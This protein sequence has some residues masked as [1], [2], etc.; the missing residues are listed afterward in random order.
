MNNS[1]KELENNL[2]KLTININNSTKNIDRLT[3]NIN[4]V[5]EKVDSVTEGIKLL[6][7]TLTRNIKIQTREI[8]KQTESTNV[9]KNA[10]SGYIKNEADLIENEINGYIEEFLQNDSRFR[11][12]NIFKVDKWEYLNI[13]FLNKEKP[14][15][16]IN[17]KD[18]PITEFD[19]LF[20]MTTDDNYYVDNIIRRKEETSNYKILQFIVVEGKHSISKE[21]IDTK[22]K[23][24][25]KFQD[26]L[27]V[28]R[29]KDNYTNL[30]RE[31]QKKIID[32]SLDE[33]DNHI[34][35]Y[36]G[37]EDMDI[38]KENKIKNTAQFWN[39]TYD[40]EVGYLKPSGNRYELYR[41]EDNFNGNYL[42]Y[43][44]SN[45][46]SINVNKVNLGKNNI[47]GNSKKSKKTKKI[48]KE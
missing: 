29:E 40:I 26:Y 2:N 36:F 21:D 33:F 9:I 13:P 18:H 11:Y 32:Y 6:G 15:I 23:Q 47:G 38:Q 48:S 7:D 22:I 1:S 42:S 20:I 46:K 16:Y 43:K 28:A 4:R 14:D 39:D 34:I 8:S 30:T 5:G 35:L 3:D 45:V 37:S 25:I 10:I 44:K 19:G 27:R 41:I 31:F 24:M 17:K 12:F